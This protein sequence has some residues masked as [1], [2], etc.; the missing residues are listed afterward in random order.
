[1]PLK[2]VISS[3]PRPTGIPPMRIR[4]TRLIPNNRGQS[5]RTW[6]RGQERAGFRQIP[7]L[8]PRPFDVCQLIAGRA[9]SLAAVDLG[10]Q[11]P[12]PQ[13]LKATPDQFSPGA[14]KG[15]RD[16]RIAPIL[17]PRVG[18]GIVGFWHRSAVPARISSSSSRTPAIMARRCSRRVAENA[19]AHAWLRQMSPFSGALSARRPAWP[20]L[21]GSR[22]NQQQG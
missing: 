14:D 3:G 4:T 13:R 8:S 15:H 10:L 1:M 9:A 22:G 19:V 12:F 5:G 2:G 20:R 16:D 6:K 21:E 11:N 17:W 18:R 7:V